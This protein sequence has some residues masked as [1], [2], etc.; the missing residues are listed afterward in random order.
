MTTGEGIFYGFVFIGLILLYTITK[1]RWRW[2]RISTWGVSTLVVSLLGIG[3]WVVSANY[4]ESRPQLATEFWGISP[5]I[6]KDELIFR[7]GKP[8]KDDGDMVAYYDT[9]NEPLYMVKMK[10]EKVRAIQAFTFAGKS[11]L[12]PSIQGISNYSTQADIERKFGIPDS[13]SVNTDKTIRMVSY[14]KYGLVFQLE[15]GVV[16][17][18]G[19]LA[20]SEGPLT[21]TGTSLHLN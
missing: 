4:W 15:K 5:G 10:G 14:L 1:D 9:E 19:V 16:V 6:T 18:L 13:V 11:H 17:A 7:K 20:P 2:K 3:L 8:T 21:F 12:L